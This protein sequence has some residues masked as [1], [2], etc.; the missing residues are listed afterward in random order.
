MIM[1]L[2][3]E[4]LKAHLAE[5][6]PSD[7][8]DV[9][10]RTHALLADSTPSEDSDVRMVYDALVHEVKSIGG[11]STMPYA[12]YAKR[13]SFAKFKAQV[14]PFL[15]FVD[16]FLLPRSKADRLKAARLLFSMILSA[17]HRRQARAS[18]SYVLNL[19][20]QVHEIVEQEFPGYRDSGMLHIILRQHLIGTHV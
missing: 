3:P 13:S 11:K 12:A 15:N 7:L 1:Q 9:Q 8:K 19:M 20:P 10:A 18:M 16:T 17:I 14:P 5:L 4:E 6:S 2:T